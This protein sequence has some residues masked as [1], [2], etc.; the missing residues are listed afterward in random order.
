MTVVTTICWFVNVSGCR[1]GFVRPS[2]E[3]APTALNL[4]A[5][6]SQAV[7]CA[8]APA[9][10]EQGDVGGPQ[11][12]EEL[13]S[14]VAVSQWLSPS[15][16]HPGGNHCPQNCPSFCE[17]CARP[18]LVVH[19]PQTCVAATAGLDFTA[20]GTGKVLPQPASALICG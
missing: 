5:N 9:Y 3:P 15:G 4:P 10:R 1:W 20:L 18:P 7:V 13:Q 2:L 14:E 6:L 16:S 17:S 12:Q 8:S 11:M 19:G